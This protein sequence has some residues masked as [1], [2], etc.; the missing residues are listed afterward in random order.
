MDWILKTDCHPE[1]SE[2]RHADA[3]YELAKETAKDNNLDIADRIREHAGV[4][5]QRGGCWYELAKD[6]ARKNN[7]NINN[8][9]G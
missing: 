7:L 6:T 1:R 4:P 5:P 9:L 3:G 2:G 8:R